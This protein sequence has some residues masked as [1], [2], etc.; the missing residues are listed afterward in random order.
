MLKLAKLSLRHRA[1][2]SEQASHDQ[3]VVIRELGDR[4]LQRLDIMKIS[5]ARILHSGVD[6]DDLQQRYPN[7]QLVHCGFAAATSKN[8]RQSICID[9]DT[10]PFAARQFDLIIMNLTPLW[11]DQIKYFL[12]E[13]YRI[14]NANGL[15]LFSTL[16]P[17]SLQEL[18]AIM[19]NRMHH[20]VDMHDIGDTLLQAKFLDPVMDMQRLNLRY[21]SVKGLLTDIK[22]HGGCNARA[23]RARGLMGKN[24]WRTLLHEYENRF[25][26]DKKKI[27]S[28]LEIITGHAWMPAEPNLAYADKDG[29]ARIPIA[30]L[31]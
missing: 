11:T 16:G 9:L 10:L 31:R 26:D 3:N 15:L 5:P 14:L 29:V 21:R 30:G 17:D 4:L 8:K 20:F 24:T 13:C 12:H 25:C 6:S 27:K 2:Q 7:A 1:Q 23:D 19:P 28:T 18:R 22:T